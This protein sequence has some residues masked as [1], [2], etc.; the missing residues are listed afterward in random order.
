MRQ[1]HVLE[2]TPCQPTPRSPASRPL[3]P[4]GAAG[5]QERILGDCR[6]CFDWGMEKGRWNWLPNHLPTLKDVLA[7]KPPGTQPLRSPLTHACVPSANDPSH[8]VPAGEIRIGLDIGGGSGSFAARMLEHNV[9][10]VTTGLNSGA[11]FLETVALRGLPAL[12]LS[13]KSRLPLLDATIDFIHTQHCVQFLSLDE[14]EYMLFD[15][16]R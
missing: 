11:P 13:I 1:L 3:M 6:E 12:H 4:E 14:F 10:M 8:T 5:I 7:L 16:D 2:G 9:T 15:W